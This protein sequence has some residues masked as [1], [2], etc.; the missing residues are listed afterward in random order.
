M[1]AARA[2]RSEN[3]AEAPV[4]MADSKPAALLRGTAR[5]LEVV[6]DA[7]APVD[8]LGVAIEKWLD[9]APA[10]FKGSDVRVRVEDGPLQAGALGRID[11]I[12]QR[13][14]LRIVEVSA[15]LPSV[16]DADAVP[17]PNLAAGSAQTATN[18]FEDEP[19]SASIGLAPIQHV[20]ETAPSEPRIEPPTEL[21][22]DELQD[23]VHLA[24]EPGPSFDEPTLTSAPIAGA[25]RAELHAVGPQTRLV[26]GPVRSGVILEHEGHLLVFG[27]VNPG[28]EIRATGNIVVLGRLRGTA[29]AGIGQ[30]LGF[31]LALHLQPQQLRIG[32]R[33][34]RS[35]DDASTT[36]A[37]IAYLTDDAI[38]VER[39]Q[40]KLPRNLASSI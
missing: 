17:E 28:A 27:D 7:T 11:A 35:G 5:G 22:H 29:H 2:T 20:D 18:N 10:F 1:E 39:Y 3:V 32:R 25:A 21:G 33:V 13:Y 9:K 8:A 23:L 26:V 24:S 38:V 31:I 36:V 14:A 6:V 15:V 30:E 37:E 16:T 4:T 19:T 12:A 40:G 34:A